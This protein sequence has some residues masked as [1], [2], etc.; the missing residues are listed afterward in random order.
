MKTILTILVLTAA[1]T[2]YAQYYF[3]WQKV[4]TVTSGNF[5]DFNPQ[6]DHGG[7]GPWR[8]SVPFE[9]LVF[10]RQGDTQSAVCA[11]KIKPTMNNGVPS[12]QWDSSVTII[13]TMPSVSSN[14]NPDISTNF[15]YMYRDSVWTNEPFTVAAWQEDEP[16]RETIVPVWDIYYSYT[17]GDEAEWAAPRKLVS[18]GEDVKVRGQSDSSF[19]FIWKTGDILMCATFANG[20]VSTPDTLVVTNYDNT[21]F[22]YELASSQPT[23]AWT[24][25]D[26]MGEVVCF[27]ARVTSLSPVV[28]SQIDTLDSDGNISNPEFISS[29]PQSMTFN[30]ENGGRFKPVLASCYSYSQNGPWQQEDL[31]SDPLSDNLNAAG[32]MPELVLTDES[33]GHPRTYQTPY[34]FFSWEHRTISDTSLIFL[35]FLTVPADTVKSTGYNRNLSM[36]SSALPQYSYEI[37]PCVWEGNRTGSSH[38]YGRV[39]IIQNGA[40]NEP[41]HRDQSFVLQQNYPN[42]FNPITMIGFQLSVAG[43]VTLKVYDVLGRLVATLL[44]GKQIPGEHSVTFDARYLSSGVYFYQLKVGNFVGTKKMLVEK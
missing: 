6:I 44:D 43:H 5:N 33:N 11:M 42:P 2:S 41:T 24:G 17:S 37:F 34:G 31:T 36:S 28:L 14:K 16:W 4:D 8:Y 26:S 30:V 7:L 15:E 19:M 23:V 38:I 21:E 39:A 35:P 40:V 3:G 32:V 18:G 1:T 22:D 29:V 9:W 10:D 20:Q 13:A 27:V 25:K 12:V